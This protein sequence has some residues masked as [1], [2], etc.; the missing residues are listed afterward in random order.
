LKL[1]FL[2][3][4]ADQGK[5]PIENE[6]RPSVNTFFKKISVKEHFFFFGGA[7]RHLPEEDRS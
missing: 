1:F 5:T 2:A 7:R 6:P 3:D 4:P